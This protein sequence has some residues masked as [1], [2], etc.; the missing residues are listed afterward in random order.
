MNNFLESS[1][2]VALSKEIR[3]RDKKCLRCSSQYRLCADH[4]IP[5]QRRKDLSLER[6]NLQTL[7]WK[8]NTDKKNNFIVSFLGNPSNR[9]L[10]EI[11]HEKTRTRIALNKIVRDRIYSSDPS[12]YS[13]I[14]SDDFKKF[15]NEYD[16]V[17]FGIDH[18]KQREREGILHTP[19]NILRFFSLGFSLMGRVGI[20]AVQ[21][22]NNQVGKSKIPQNEI[23]EYIEIE[24]NRIFSDWGGRQINKNIEK[25]SERIENIDGIAE[26]IQTPIPV[27]LKKAE[28]VVFNVIEENA[29]YKI[30]NR[31]NN[32]GFSIVLCQYKPHPNKYIAYLRNKKWR[33]INF[34]AIEKS[35]LNILHN[36]V[37]DFSNKPDLSESNL[38]SSGIKVFKTREYNA[39]NEIKEHDIRRMLAINAIDDDLIED[40]ST[41]ESNSLKEDI[42]KSLLREN[43]IT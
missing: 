32:N 1:E 18:P 33:N 15:T 23:S 6:F 40:I 14:N 26:Y 2:W 22:I 31:S 39:E 25:K 35:D 30:Y 5:R 20:A 42:V 11:K 38:K 34:I 7:C 21:E 3:A 8:C 37:K 16:L 43:D 29:K 28:K 10:S 19:I 36:H 17:T 12:K 41:K 9:L 4:I 13:F 24:I 27:K